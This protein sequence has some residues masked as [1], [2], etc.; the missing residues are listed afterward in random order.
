MSL[1]KEFQ[2]FVAKGNAIDLAVGVVIGAAFT[3]VVNSIT[4]GF[5]RPLLSLLAPDPSVGL[6]IGPF[7]VGLVITALINFFLVAVVVFLFIV[8]P[9]NALRRQLERHE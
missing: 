8:K 7:Q 9:M 4:D 2:D 6:V 1:L 5:I 3:N